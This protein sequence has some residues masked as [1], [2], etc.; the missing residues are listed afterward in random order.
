MLQSAPSHSKFCFSV[1]HVQ[2][3]CASPAGFNTYDLYD[4][5]LTFDNFDDRSLSRSLTLRL[6][7]TLFTCFYLL[8]LPERSVPS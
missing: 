6:V 1:S 4:R 3:V 2:T 5:S 8:V 7:T